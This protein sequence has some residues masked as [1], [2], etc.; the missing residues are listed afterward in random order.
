MAA[1]HIMLC[2]SS[3]L[4]LCWH[5][6]PLD[7]LWR[8]SQLE[9][10]KRLPAVVYTVFLF[11][12]LIF[13]GVTTYKDYFLTWGNDPGLYTHYNVGVAE[14]GEFI[15]TLPE[16]ETIYLSPTWID[17]STLK[18]HAN[19]REGI[20]AYNGRH[21]FVYPEKTTAVTSYIIVPTDEANS[22]PLAQ[23]AFP[24]GQTSREERYYTAYQIPA[25][26]PAQLESQRP[27]YTNWDD[28]LSLIG[29]DISGDTFN[30]GDSITVNL[31]TQPLTDMS[32]NY[33]AFIHL[34]GSADPETGNTIWAQVDREPCFQSYPTS[35]WQEGEIIRDTYTLVIN[36]ETP[37]G[38]Y[39]MM[40]G[41]YHWP[42][43]TRLNSVESTHETDNQAVILQSI[44][45]L[46]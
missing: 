10:G 11:V 16:S 39:E 15:N 13:S 41:F 42:E 43:L 45:V 3:V 18:L 34:L 7:W 14:I 20:R 12:G 33:T 37:S 25:D 46:P 28:E 22:L 1:W 36:P 8:R 17:H 40:M 44:E 21:C 19:N 24:N 32:S 5:L 2:F 26:S 6:R 4:G 9:S 38:T 23:T 31:Y 29:Y 27:L 30:A 35:W